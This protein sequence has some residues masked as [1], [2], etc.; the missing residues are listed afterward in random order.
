MLKLFWNAG[1]ACTPDEPTGQ[2]L[3]DTLVVGDRAATARQ[4]FGRATPGFPPLAISVAG[5][6]EAW[7]ARR[8]QPDGPV[9][10]LLHGFQ[11]APNVPDSSLSSP[12]GTIYGYPGAGGPDPHLTLLPL[13]GECDETGG[14][15]QDVAIGFAWTSQG[16]IADD[17]NAGWD[18]DYKY[19]ALDLAPA[20][21]KALASLLAHLAMR[22]VAVRLLAH[23]LGTRAASQAI[24]LLKA[25]GQPSS[26]ERAV[27][28]G[29]AEFAVDAAANFAGCDFDV[30]NIG[31]RK[32]SVLVLGED[33]CHPVR[34]NN[35]WAS[36]VLGRNGLG[37]NA[38]W[39]DL[40]LDR[41]DVVDWF[42]A[43]RAPSGVAYRLDA[44]AESDVHSF[45][46]WNH[47]AYYTNDGNRA[48]VRDLM[49]RP[50]MRAHDLAAAPDG[51]DCPEY[52]KFDG[53]EVPPTPQTRDGRETHLAEGA[54]GG[55]VA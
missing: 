26:L 44:Q 17:G 49:T 50:D 31:S 51:F 6:L 13:V 22:K 24:G 15:R 2:L 32:D 46:A 8:A 28:L 5:P 41:A 33:A 7:L 3:V 55:H 4:A 21:A 37:G 1:P 42:A 27:L 45:G 23:S 36:F 38:R 40:Q 11:Y 16:S 18:N 43:G 47:W 34:V 25:A 9:Y 14:N 53:Q 29:A 20:C 35:S 54:H 52:G 19:A 30:V 39:H 10:L 12:F 48:L